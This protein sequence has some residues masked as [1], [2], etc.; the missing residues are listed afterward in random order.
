[1]SSTV[2]LLESIIK[3][4]GHQQ[5]VRFLNSCDESRVFTTEVDEAK[6]AVAVANRLLNENSSRRDG[7]LVLKSLLGQIPSESLQANLFQWLQ[8]ALKGLSQKESS[9]TVIIAA[10]VI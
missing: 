9:T 2:E 10:E 6:T 7:L 5:L 4:G 1:M 3:F 8:Q